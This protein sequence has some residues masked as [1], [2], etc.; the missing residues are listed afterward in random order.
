MRDRLTITAVEDVVTAESLE[1]ESRKQ[2][3]AD[4]EAAI[5]TLDCLRT[6]KTCMANL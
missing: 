2:L 6:F 3:I 1:A 4:L 5:H